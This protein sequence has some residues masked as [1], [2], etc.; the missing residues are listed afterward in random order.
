MAIMGY[1]DYFVTDLFFMKYDVVLQLDIFFFFLFDLLF[2]LLL[3][4]V[5][6]YLPSD[7]IKL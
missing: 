1:V 5:A 2:V 7:C 4:D 3:H 6:V